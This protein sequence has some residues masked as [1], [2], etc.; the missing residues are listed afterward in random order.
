MNKFWRLQPSRAMV[1]VHLP[2]SFVL[3]A[4]IGTSMLALAMSEPSVPLPDIDISSSQA[5]PLSTSLLSTSNELTFVDFLL[6]DFQSARTVKFTVHECTLVHAGRPYSVKC[7]LTMDTAIHPLSTVAVIILKVGFSIAVPSPLSKL[8]RV[9][10]TTLFVGVLALAFKVIF[11]PFSSKDVTTAG[12][13]DASRPMAAVVLPGSLVGPLV[14]LLLSAVAVPTTLQPL[15][16]I[17][18]V[19]RHGGG[20]TTLSQIVSPLACVGFA[21]GFMSLSPVAVSH[22]ACRNRPL[23]VVSVPVGDLPGALRLTILK[24]ADEAPDVRRAVQK[25]Q[26][27]LSM[28]F[29]IEEL[30]TKVRRIGPQQPT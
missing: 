14:A 5:T 6:E 22:E 18:P 15:P 9:G 13:Q 16:N 3:R 2:L 29:P 27:A 12:L 20:A 26:C 28:V 30:T 7:S 17:L 25:E 4:A 1:D 19:A 8:P 10:L 21:R 24:E 11:V 23:E